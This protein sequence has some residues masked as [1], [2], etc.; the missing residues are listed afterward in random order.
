[1]SGVLNSSLNGSATNITDGAGR[2]FSSSFSGQPGAGTPVFHHTG[3]QGLHNMHTNFNVPSMAGSLSSRNSAINGVPSGGMQQSSGNLLAGRFG[4]NNITD[5]LSQI[6]HGVSHG[7]SGISNRGGMNIVGSPG[8]SNGTN[9]VGGSIHGVLPTS[10]AAGNRGAMPG[11]GVSPMMGNSG[12]RITSSMGNIV[13][14]GNIGRNMSSG[15]GLSVP[16]MTSRLNFTTNNASGGSGLQGPNGLMGGVL[17]QGKTKKKIKPPP[18]L[19]THNHHTGTT[20]SVPLLLRRRQLMYLRAGVTHRV[21]ISSSSSSKPLTPPTETTATTLWSNEV[22]LRRKGV[23][24]RWQDKPMGDNVEWSAPRRSRCLRRQYMVMVAVDVVLSMLGTSYVS[25]GNLLSQ[26]HGQAV[27]SLSSRAML[28]DMNSNDTPFAMDDFPSL[29]SR[30]NSAGAPQGQIGSMRKQGLGGPIGQRN[31]EF[32]IQNEDF[33]AL[34]GFKGGSV[35]FG[36]DFRQKDQLQDNNVSMMQSQHFSMGRS[37][38]FTLGGTYSSQQPQHQQ[39]HLPS[40]SGGSDSFTS[41]NN[42]RLLQSHGSDMFPS[43]N[44]TFHIQGNRPSDNN[45]R[46]V[47]NISTISS[48]ASYDQRMQQYQQQSQSQFHLRQMPAVNQS[49]RDQGVKSIQ[50]TQPAADSFGLLG[51][52][53]VIRM[54]DPDLTSL[55]LGIDLTTLGLNLNSSEDLHKSFGSPWS[56]EPAKGDPEFVVPHCYLE[57]LAPPL[58]YL[59]FMKFALGLLFYIFYSMPKDEAQLY[60][61][62]EL[63]RRGWSYHKELRVWLSR[64]TNAEPPFQTATFERGSYKFFDP[65]TWQETQKDNFVLQYESLEKKLTLNQH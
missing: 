65:T 59:H 10:A 63:H 40:V 1:M 28:H 9:V 16:G 44:S 50:A 29:G 54:S 3:I 31:Q 35:D 57:K 45:L 46:S 42:Q 30:P 12:S 38:G 52:L 5:P 60:A 6:S 26:N 23:D 39:Q 56:D 33:P 49:F 14:S 27:N 47:N 43:S 53:G 55:A 18:H 11:L 51:L 32:S 20:T 13:G 7:H 4:S 64:I 61:A 2:S 15:A 34:P 41:A 58:N 17:Q 24:Q 22:G 48:A 62:H 37:P 36:M 8:Y 21:P 25:G 19:E